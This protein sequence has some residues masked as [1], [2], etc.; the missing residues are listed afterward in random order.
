M[1]HEKERTHQN[2]TI[3]M[4]KFIV[5]S[6]IRGCGREP[7]NKHRRANNH[8][9]AIQFL[10]VVY[11]S[12]YSP[13]L[14]FLPYLLLRVLVPCH[15]MLT[16]CVCFSLLCLCRSSCVSSL[17]LFMDPAMDR[18]TPTFT[19]NTTTTIIIIKYRVNVMKYYFHLYC[20]ESK[21]SSL[22]LTIPEKSTL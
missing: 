15:A 20:T 21:R 22:I 19:I 3:S 5:K 16:L 9:I 13:N 14:I 1:R 7:V 6:L 12:S 17:S 11:I 18:N 8:N 10:L 4:G 2:F